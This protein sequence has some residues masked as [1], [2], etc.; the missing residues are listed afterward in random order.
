MSWALDRGAVDC[1]QRSC[2][3]LSIDSPFLL[4]IRRRRRRL[5]LLPLHQHNQALQGA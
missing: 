3:I 4:C 2:V 1:R 5:L